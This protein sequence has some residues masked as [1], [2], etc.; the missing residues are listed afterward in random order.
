MIRVSGLHSEDHKETLPHQPQASTVELPVSSSM[1][2]AS[3]S[4]RLWHSVAL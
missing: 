4:P 1:M 2:D 3:A